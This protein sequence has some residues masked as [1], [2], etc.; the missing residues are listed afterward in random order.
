MATCRVRAV[1]SD[2]IYW[3]PY[4]SYEC[5]DDASSSSISTSQ[6]VYRCASYMLTSVLVAFYIFMFFIMLCSLA[7]LFLTS[8][9]L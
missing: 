8:D 2:Y 7:A 5:L 6:P 3:L 9:M 1:C 4:F